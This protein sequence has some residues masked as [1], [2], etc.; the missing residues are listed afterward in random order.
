MLDL[1][2]LEQQSAFKL[3]G[4]TVIYILKIITI[5]ILIKI[6]WTDLKTK[7][8]PDKWIA[9][10]FIVTLILCAV[11]PECGIKER[12]YGGLIV[13]LPLFICAVCIPGSFGGGDIKLMAA[14]GILLGWKQTLLAF[15]IAIYMA[16]I[17][18]GVFM[19]TKK[20]SRK[21]AIPFGPALCFG[22]TISFLWGETIGKCFL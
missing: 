14:A 17:G 21:D 18:I 6:G 11:Y 19:L 3:E 16:G 15:V 2:Q 4:Y 7:T 12:I 13:S 22:I 8:I 1:E 10:F 9:V 20:L 5:C